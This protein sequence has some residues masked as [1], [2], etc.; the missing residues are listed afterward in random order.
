MSLDKVLASL[1]GDAAKTKKNAQD[2]GAFLKS[3]KLKKY[4]EPAT[5][6]YN[7][8]AKISGFYFTYDRIVF[9]KVNVNAL[10]GFTDPRLGGILNSFEYLNPDNT[11][12]TESAGNLTKEFRYEYRI[13]FNDARITVVIEVAARVKEDSP[14]CRKEI[15]G[16]TDPKPV[17][18]YKIVCDDGADTPALTTEREPID[19]LADDVLTSGDIGEF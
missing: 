5:S 16:Y 15:V 9:F 10:V 14:T 8:D 19:H 2:I 17:P 4:A 7:A 18:I 13:K 11:S 1:V 3:G 6:I 12:V